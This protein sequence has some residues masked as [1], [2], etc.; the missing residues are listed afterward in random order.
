MEDVRLGLAPQ[1]LETGAVIKEDINLSEITFVR[2][3]LRSV[4][5]NLINNA[6]K[7]TPKDRIPEIMIKSYKEKN[8][9][10]VSVSD[11]GMGISKELKQSIFE[12]FKRLKSVQEGAGVGLY[13]VHTIVT[14]AEGKITLESEPGKGSDF[15]IH[16]KI[17]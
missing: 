10:V 17:K 1:I 15:K 5:Y 6:I 2:R 8:Y 7:Y 9:M 12:K 11:N 3:K 13:L 4:I 16:L 14:L